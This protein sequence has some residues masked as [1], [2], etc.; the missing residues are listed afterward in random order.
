MKDFNPDLAEPV[1]EDS[2]M[3]EMDGFL[4]RLDKRAKSFRV[5]MIADAF[6]ELAN[7]AKEERG[8]LLSVAAKDFAALVE[9]EVAKATESITKHVCDACE[10]HVAEHAKIM[11][12]G[13]QLSTKLGR[14]DKLIRDLTTASRDDQ[15][16]ASSVAVMAQIRDSVAGLQSALTVRAQAEEANEGASL[17]AILAAVREL[18]SVPPPP[19]PIWNFRIVRDDYLR[20]SNVI[21]EVQG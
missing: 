10:T 2:D 11:A 8:K 14:L 4:E 19:K 7:V 18:K 13:E 5:T 21:A 12:Q 15:T 9:E 16:A 3:S 6:K 20:I 17:S 1:D